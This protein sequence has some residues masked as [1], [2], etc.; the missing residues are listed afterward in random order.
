MLAL[1]DW[2]IALIV[3]G[4]LVFLLFFAAYC[5]SLAGKRGRQPNTGFLFGFFLGPFGI[6]L[7]YLLPEGDY[8]PIAL[9][10][11]GGEKRA[12][13]SEEEPLDTSTYVPCENCGNIVFATHVIEGKCPNCGAK[14]RQPH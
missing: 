11:R 13:I 12:E 10:M 8:S 6:L 4:V 7:L 9:Y 2:I 1:A 3:L 14:M 5:S